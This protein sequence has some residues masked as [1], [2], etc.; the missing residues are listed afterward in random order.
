MKRSCIQGGQHFFM[1]PKYL[2]M[3][4]T[5]YYVVQFLVAGWGVEF[6]TDEDV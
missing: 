3:K 4:T 1:N 5:E 6:V 2:E